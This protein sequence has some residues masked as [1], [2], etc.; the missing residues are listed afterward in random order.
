MSGSAASLC[1]LARAI[2]ALD[3]HVRQRLAGA[4]AGRQRLRDGALRHGLRAGDHFRG[5]LG[6]R[7][8]GLLRRDGGR[9]RVQF[10]PV[11]PAVLGGRITASL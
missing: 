8:G 9:D 4:R 1:V 3:D 6:L 7:R 5:R 11:D 2:V 10:R